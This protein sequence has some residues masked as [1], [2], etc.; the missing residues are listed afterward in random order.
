MRQCKR[1]LAKLF[2]PSFLLQ[3]A[4]SE[5]HFAACRLTL[6]FIHY[7]STQRRPRGIYYKCGIRFS[8]LFLRAKT[9]PLICFSLYF[10]S[11]R[12]SSVDI[13]LFKRRFGDGSGSRTVARN[14][15]FG[16]WQV[17]CRR[18]V[19]EAEVCPPVEHVEVDGHVQ[20]QDLCD[21]GAY[22]CKR[23]RENIR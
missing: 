4:D 16:G 9:P 19:H 23:S 8:P 12:S 18:S 6:F 3:A 17:D 10:A 1:P 15:G 7:A 5:S 11:D 21:H 22:V 14:H 20:V 13:P 2:V